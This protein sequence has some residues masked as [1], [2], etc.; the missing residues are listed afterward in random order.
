VNEREVDVLA[1]AQR[2]VKKGNHLGPTHLLEVREQ[3]TLDEAQA[4]F[5][6]IAR[7]AHPDMHRTTMTADQLDILTSAYSRVSAAYQEFKSRR[8]GGRPSAPGMDG[9]TPPPQ[10]RGISGIAPAPQQPAKPTTKAPLMAPKAMLYYR[11]AESALR[12]GDFRSA[13]LQLKMAIAAD[14]QSPVL[15]QALT[16]VESEIKKG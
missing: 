8:L 5:H 12:Q 13:L 11:K 2:I 7:V 4:A 9:K 14:P 6:R 15:R 1:W 10:L 16:E 3:A